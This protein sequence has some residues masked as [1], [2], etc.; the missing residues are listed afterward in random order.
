ME[1]KS[2]DSD[3][4]YDHIDPSIAIEND[5]IFAENKIKDKNEDGIELESLKQSQ[6][7]D[8]CEDAEREIGNQINKCENET[9]KDE[10]SPKSSNEDLDSE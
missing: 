8:V 5:E 9:V 3:E 7:N 10:S 6:N 2:Q 1:Q 4:V